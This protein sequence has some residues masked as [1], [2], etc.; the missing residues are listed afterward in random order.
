M[1]SSAFLISS[2]SYSSSLGGSGPNDDPPFWADE[3]ESFYSS[4]SSPTLA[5]PK[6][7]SRIFTPSLVISSLLP[8]A[9][10]ELFSEAV[11]LFWED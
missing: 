10:L 5:L 2:G 4:L 3:P 6:T 7:S 11:L 1:N 9:E 8:A